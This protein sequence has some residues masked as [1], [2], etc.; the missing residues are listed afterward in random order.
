MEHEQIVRQLQYAWEFARAMG[1]A[2]CLAG[3]TYWVTTWGEAR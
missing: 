3:V 2:F 1:P